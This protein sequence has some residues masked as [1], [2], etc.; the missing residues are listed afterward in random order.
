MIKKWDEKKMVKIHFN[1]ENLMGSYVSFSF[2]YF[3]A[4]LAYKEFSTQGFLKQASI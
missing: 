4:I 2:Q 1:L 3:Y